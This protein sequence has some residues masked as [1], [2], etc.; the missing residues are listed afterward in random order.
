MASEKYTVTLDSGQTVKFEGPK[1]WTDTEI[2][3]EAR[4]RAGGFSGV[5]ERVLDAADAPEQLLAKALGS[6]KGP[7]VTRGVLGTLLPETLGE[8]AGDAVMTVM[9]LPPGARLAGRMVG[10]AAPLARAA[11]SGGTTTA[12]DT[13]LGDP[14]ALRRGL[15]QGGGSLGGEVVQGLVRAGAR[16][17][18]KVGTRASDA[19]N[20]G[21]AINDVIPNDGT[22]EDL[23]KKVFGKEGAEVSG[24][25]LDALQSSVDDAVGLG[26]PS[27]QI[28]HVRLPQPLADELFPGKLTAKASD[29]I[30]ALK[31]YK[32]E[33]RKA[34]AQKEPGAQAKTL[35]MADKLEGMFRASLLKAQ[36]DGKAIAAYDAYNQFATK[37]AAVLQFLRESGFIQKGPKGPEVQL[38]TLQEALDDFAQG[39]RTTVL[40]RLERAGL[41]DFIEAVTRHGAPGSQDVSFNPLHFVTM[42]AVG[43]GRVGSG[44]PLDVTRFAGRAPVPSA[45]P[46]YGQAAGVAGSRL[47]QSMMGQR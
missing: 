19:R 46:L 34:F 40:Q 9:G 2:M 31:G 29:V 39:K 45:S 35:D 30:Q 22:P 15:F 10:K 26:D 18:A 36:P 16:N 14:T 8:V 28:G 1:D 11:V 33:A 32:A 25:R 17:V 7:G 41:N 6:Q 4:R 47:M 38:A 13:M 23:F 42:G 44:V 27:A 21:N 37:R 3:S 24:K 43:S 12:V 5:R 20:L